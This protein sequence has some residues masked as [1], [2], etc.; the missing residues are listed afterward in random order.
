MLLLVEYVSY[1]TPFECQDK[2]NG[3]F[4]T[5]A[6]VCSCMCM[7]IAAAAATSVECA[8]PGC[9]L[10]QK[11]DKNIPKRQPLIASEV[12]RPSDLNIFEIGLDFP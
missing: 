4:F 1:P 5:A 8:E 3:F 7:C 9:F 6:A 12:T 2:T 11:L 10:P